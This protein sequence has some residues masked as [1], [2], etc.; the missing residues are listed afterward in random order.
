MTQ[1]QIDDLQEAFNA[2]E[3]EKKR[4]A[5]TMVDLNSKK[6]ALRRQCDHKN[7]DGTIAIYFILTTEV[8]PICLWRD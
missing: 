8:C 2:I 7:A 4:H 1:E 3:E 5:D 6:D